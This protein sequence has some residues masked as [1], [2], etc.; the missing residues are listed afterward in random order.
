MRE[1]DD[2]FDSGD[3]EEEEEER[4][5]SRFKMKKVNECFDCFKREI[6]VEK[7]RGEERQVKFEFVGDER[8]EKFIEKLIIDEFKEYMDK[9]EVV[10]GR[11]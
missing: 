8:F 11:I 3:D 5:K 2:D 9:L 10:Y 4:G 1:C 7:K 6:E